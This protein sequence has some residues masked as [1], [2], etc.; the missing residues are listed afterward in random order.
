[1]KT[2]F[3][4]WILAS[5]AALLFYV[6]D[7]RSAEDSFARQTSVHGK[8]EYVDSPDGR[9][10]YEREGNGPAI[11]LVAGGPGGSHASFHPWFSELAKQYAVIYFDNVGRGRSDRLKDA[12]RYT[13]ER[14][15]DD[16]E[17]LRQKLGFEKLILIGHSYGGM[18]A[19]AYALRRPDR[20]ERLILSDSAVSA[21]EWQ[22]NID[23]CNHYVQL[24]Y[25]EI[26]GQLL[27]LRAKGVKSSASAYE[28]LY[29]SALKNVYWFNPE[30]KSKMI[31]STDPQDALNGNVY[32][33]MLGD[34]PEWT[35][36]GTIKN[37]DPRASLKNV[38]IP[39]LVTVGRSDEVCP[40]IVARDLRASFPAENSRLVVFER[41]GHRPWVEE[42]EKWFLLV[43]KFL[44]NGA[45]AVPD[46]SAQAA[47]KGD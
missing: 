3:I 21:D 40:P 34:D 31:R 20:V 8:G 13:V 44:E 39:T 11:F 26:W 33:A 12:S 28:N 14:D 35:V 22:L 25:P 1:M 45:A 30:A 19:M 18:P 6:S 4:R 7:L 23:N 10:Y 17:V 27:A 37:F 5:F 15:A 42:S 43:G 2:T 41:S 32:L 16:I 36:G 47:R 9:I 24:H 46:D 38:K 29:G